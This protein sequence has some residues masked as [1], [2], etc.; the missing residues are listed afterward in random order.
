MDQEQIDRLMQL[1]TI[2]NGLRDLTHDELL[3]YNHLS[4][5]H[6]HWTSQADEPYEPS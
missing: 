2:L 3:E 6:D 5:M 1:E 4:A